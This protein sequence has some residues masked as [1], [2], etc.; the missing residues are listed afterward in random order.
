[1]AEKKI[2][3][4]DLVLINRGGRAYKTEVSE[5]PVFFGDTA[6]GSPVTGDA[7]YNSGKNIL[8]VYN[9]T[10]YVPQGV[11][12]APSQPPT[13]KSSPGALWFDT[14]VGKLKYYD[15]DT[16]TWPTVGAN[17]IGELLDVEDGASGLD[18]L[19]YD[20][21]SSEWKNVDI[22]TVLSA[23]KVEDLGDVT[24]TAADD[25]F[26]SYQ[27][28]K[29][30]I[31]PVAAD[32]GDLTNN[33]STVKIDGETI[34]VNADGKIF[35]SID[36]ALTFKDPVDVCRNLASNEP[37]ASAAVGDLYVHVATGPTDPTGDTPDPSWNLSVITV[38]TGDLV[39]KTA[40]N[41]WEVIGRV[42]DEVSGFVQ[43]AGDTMTG[44]LTV[45][46]DI[47]VGSDIKLTGADGRASFGGDEVVIA[48]DN[49]NF[50]NNVLSVNK[51]PGLIT[52]ERGQTTFPAVQDQ[53]VI[54]LE[55]LKDN[56]GFNPSDPD[57]AGGYVKIKGDTMTGAL[58]LGSTTLNVDGSA[59]FGSDVTFSASGNAVSFSSTNESGYASDLTVSNSKS[60]ITKGQV[61]DI[62][63]L[64][65]GIDPSAPDFDSSLYVRKAGDEMDYGK[66]I[67]LGINP[68]DPMDA[69]TLQYL[70][71]EL[72]K[73]TFTTTLADLT[74][75]NIT[76]PSSGE[77]LI[78]DGSVWVNQVIPPTV[79][80]LGELDDVT[81]TGAAADDFIVG[82]GTGYKNIKPPVA[83]DGTLTGNLGFVR[84]EDNYT[85]SS[86]GTQPT[87]IGIDSDGII[88]STLDLP[89]ALEFKGTIDCTVDGPTSIIPAAQQ[90]EIYV[91]LDPKGSPDSIT[92]YI[93]PT[94]A[95]EGIQTVVIEGGEM[96]TGLDTT[97]DGTIDTWYI[98][99][100]LA[101]NDFDAYVMKH[102]DTMTGSLIV[103]DDSATEIFAKL[104]NA[105]GVEA[106]NLT[107]REHTILGRDGNGCVDTLN[108]YATS[109]FHCPVTFSNTVGFDG[110]V[111]ITD[112]L[113]VSGKINLTGTI[114]GGG[115]EGNLGNISI[116]TGGEITISGKPNLGTGCSDELTVNATTTFHCPVELKDKLVLGGGLTVNGDLELTGDL[117][118]SGTHTHTGDLVLTG[119]V[120]ATGKLDLTGDVA[121]K[122]DVS[123]GTGC[124]DKFTVNAA[125][126]FKCETTF[127]HNGLVTISDG[128]IDVSK[129]LTVAGNTI[130][131]GVTA[132]NTALGSLT[133]TNESQF[134]GDVTIGNSGGCGSGEEVKIYFPTTIGCDTTIEG[135]LTLEG[136][137]KL[138][139]LEI[140]TSGDCGVKGL[141]VHTE[142]E[143][144]CVTTHKENLIVDKFNL[145]LIDGGNNY[146]KVVSNSSNTV[147][148]TIESNKISTTGDLSV[149]GN[150]V[151]GTSALSGSLRVYGPSKF[152][153]TALER[154]S[155]VD[156]NGDPQLVAI[157]DLQ[158][159]ELIQKGAVTSHVADEIGKI[160]ITTNLVDLDD[161]KDNVPLTVMPGDTVV[162]IDATHFKVGEMPVASNSKR[163]GVRVEGGTTNIT[164]DADGVISASLPGVM[165]FKG[166]INKDELEARPDNNDSKYGSGATVGD[167]YVYTGDATGGIT[168]D[169]KVDATPNKA[170]T[171]DATT[172]WNDLPDT[173]KPGDLIGKGETLWG[174]VGSS[175]DIDLDE[176]VK[177]EG[178]IM[179]GPLVITPVAGVNTAGLTVNG[180][181]TLNTTSISTTLGV[182]GATTL[183]ST[184]GVA[185]KATLS[186]ELS[187]ASAAE[188]SST[189]K[190]A[191]RAQFSESNLAFYGTG[192]DAGELTYLSTLIGASEASVLITRQYLEDELGDITYPYVKLAGDNMTG[193]LTL[194]PD[195]G[196][197]VTTLDATTGAATF[198]GQVDIG[199]DATDGTK[200]AYYK[201]SDASDG[202]NDLTALQTAIEGSTDNVLVTKG[203]VDA[204]ELDAYV[205]K[206]GDTMTGALVI[207]IDPANADDPKEGSV[208]IEIDATNIAVVAG[209]VEALELSN[210][211][212]TQGDGTYTDVATTSDGGGTNLTVTY[213]VASNVVTA[214]SI[215]SNAGD[216]YLSGEVVTA[217][218]D[219]AQF[220]VINESAAAIRV[221]GASGVLA[222]Q[223][224]HDIE[225]GNIVGGSTTLDDTA[226]SSL[227]VSDLAEFGKGQGDAN[228]SVEAFTHMEYNN[229]SAF[230]TRDL[231]AAGTTDDT[232]IP[233]WKH[234]KKIVEDTVSN[235]LD[236]SE[237]ILHYELQPVTYT[238][239][240]AEYTA[241]IEIDEVRYQ[242]D[243][244]EIERTPEKELI[245]FRAGENV[246]ITK[247]NDFGLGNDEDALEISAAKSRAEVSPTPPNL[248]NYEQG[249]LW[250][251]STDGRLYM[252]YM[253]Y[254]NG[255]AD[256]TEHLIWIDASPAALNGGDFLKRNGDT[257]ENYFNVGASSSDPAVQLTYD[258]EFFAQ[259]YQ[260][261]KLPSITTFG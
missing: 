180:V 181:T 18:L 231:D 1:M 80:E 71:T 219:T 27:T 8:Y 13:D 104:D 118:T 213:T 159:T 124:S 2:Q 44:D 77:A 122:G 56:I 73:L 246:T 20:A 147:N 254:P 157:G 127:S 227:I 241:Q 86:L 229:L 58:N 224:T 39:V 256:G 79:T 247:V 154:A 250:Y 172:G 92:G 64:V 170:D 171:I 151:L 218:G 112:E 100:R 66:T 16:N 130:L 29:W 142:S 143:F 95:W 47:Y 198:S 84:V 212:S 60:W 12:Y 252:A 81:I 156:V 190:V 242:E 108:V 137:V 52:F 186:D 97:S 257:V 232:K 140:G 83:G 30:V 234:V 164:I 162:A 222:L 11:A 36:G 28:D 33:Y 98:V 183:S 5:L 174:I 152:S 139:K 132:G 208:G 177:I 146:I 165:V 144:N 150:A 14:S 67:K 53:D 59:T 106:K 82:T 46:T 129:N 63:E 6:A 248:D 93:Y 185:G 176:Y 45:E 120:T 163:G 195:G 220:T 9:G 42:V 160:T 15:A 61:E 102:G 173:V 253:N 62:V 23:A 48:S 133:V 115:V 72:G 200:L 188:L 182:T 161:V 138:P 261:E 148:S 184:L 123:V 111:T 216:G 89:P 199:L 119:D 134:N 237:K 178:D 153:G 215:G 192:L 76:T 109:T 99:G 110:K 24:G 260:L 121:L 238:G 205:L 50:Y 221:T 196:P 204:L 17:K 175:S 78:Y 26:L 206:T 114:D 214:V 207:G 243:G 31:Q 166:G 228:A 135:K 203:Y 68:S 90:G 40:A 96:I 49:T 191:G 21:G 240:S 3:L 202:S 239:A 70:S 226:V 117:E 158:P 189:L 34:K 37:Y 51:T 249:D 65:T 236:I 141:V 25:S 197:V 245:K 54:N 41:D 32:T 235:G 85:D 38:V 244:T 193:N 251:N 19:R 168:S 22:A 225:V 69:V 74:D 75:T 43:K 113:V 217:V 125:S 223:T 103:T 57:H 194:G 55:F 107:V 88:Y 258:T 255:T 259:V 209:P 179:T 145:D 105:F 155:Y 91:Q 128:S 116:G 233:A 4:T 87:N 201:V 210:T 101:N 131:D 211:A 126:E 149:G 230:Y 94:L 7:Y 10:K 167:V 35:A 169:P 136:E 187:V